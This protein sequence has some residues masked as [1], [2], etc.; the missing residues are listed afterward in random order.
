MGG[1]AC[2]VDDVTALPSHI[3]DGG[4]ALLWQRYDKN[5]MASICYSTSSTV[6]SYIE[7]VFFTL[8][9]SHTL[10]IL[11]VKDKLDV[12]FDPKPVWSFTAQRRLENTGQYFLLLRARL[13]RYSVL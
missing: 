9:S 1:S 8:F 5:K 3:Q 13:V 7:L 6:Q 12:G 11:Q 4:Y 2:K 10:K